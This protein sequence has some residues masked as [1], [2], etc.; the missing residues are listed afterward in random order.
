MHCRTLPDCKA[1]SN[2]SLGCRLDNSPACHAAWEACLEAAGV[3]C[4]QCIQLC[5]DED[6][7]HC[8]V[9][10]DEAYLRV[11]VQVGN[12]RPSRTSTQGV[13]HHC[14][15]YRDMSGLTGDMYTNT[16]ACDHACPDTFDRCM[17][18]RVLSRHLCC[19]A[20]FCAVCRV[21][22]NGRCDLVHGRDARPAR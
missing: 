21:L 17:Q 16:H 12:L 3:R 5:L 8:H 7:V 14:G 19:R 11:C 6:I 2:G 4:F 18:H 13:T 20:D 22:Q 1:L 10:E 15:R 9:G